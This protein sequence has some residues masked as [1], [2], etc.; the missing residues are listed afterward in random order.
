MEFPPAFRR[1]KNN[2]LMNTDNNCGW[3]FSVK[4]VYL[5]ALQVHF[6]RAILSII[7]SVFFSKFRSK[8]RNKV[9]ILINNA[10]SESDPDYPR[11]VEVFKN[12]YGITF[13]QKISLEFLHFFT[14][15]YIF[16]TVF[17]IFLPFFLHFLP[18][19]FTFFTLFNR[20]SIF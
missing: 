18:F 3:L 12:L 17:Y 9:K 20:F 6:Y 2:V 10:T 1:K 13:F 4:S 7:S 15:F 14:V 11:A 8:I 16:F 5:F 19:F